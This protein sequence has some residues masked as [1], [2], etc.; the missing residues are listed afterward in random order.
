MLLRYKWRMRWEVND[1]GELMSGKLSAFRY[2]SHFTLCKGHQ[3]VSRS[4]LV[5]EIELK[6]ATLI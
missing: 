6:M 4:A 2:E 3:E 5:K 1:F